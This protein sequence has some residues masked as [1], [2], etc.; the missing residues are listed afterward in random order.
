MLVS[1]YTEMLSF[2]R[3]QA[4]SI[5][6]TVSSLVD[7]HRSSRK[8]ASCPCTILLTSKIGRSPIKKA[9]RCIHQVKIISSCTPNVHQPR[10]PRGYDPKLSTLSD[11][12]VTCALS[13]CLAVRFQ[14]H[15]LSTVDT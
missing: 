12:G 15:L 10:P 4:S 9:E 3:L 6:S 1:F 13:A 7:E 8:H 14:T 5:P 11:H 2:G